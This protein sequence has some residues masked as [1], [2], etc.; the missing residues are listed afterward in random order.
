M[1]VIGSEELAAAD[2]VLTAQTKYTQIMEV[3]GLKISKYVSGMGIDKHVF[4]LH[5]C[6]CGQRY[7][8]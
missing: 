8:Y 7:L 3:Q 2:C 1:N 4:T 5:T 6:H